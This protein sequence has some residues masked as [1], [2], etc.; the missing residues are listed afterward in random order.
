MIKGSSE[1]NENTE[2]DGRSSEQPDNMFRMGS[3]G[4]NMLTPVVE[5]EEKAAFIDFDAI[6][7]QKKIQLK[8]R[9]MPDLSP[10]KKHEGHHN[11]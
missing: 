1:E 9:P 3:D 5:E 11:R 2:K 10:A 8:P 6:N 4:L 7:N